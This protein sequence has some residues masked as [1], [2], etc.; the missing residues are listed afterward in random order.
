MEMQNRILE[1]SILIQPTGSRRGFV[2]YFIVEKIVFPFPL[3]V[4]LLGYR[5]S[6]VVDVVVEK[7]I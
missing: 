3:V 6:Y 7:R 4:G 2:C 1:R 5:Y